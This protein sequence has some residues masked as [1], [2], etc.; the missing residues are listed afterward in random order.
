MKKK[1]KREPEG[2]VGKMKKKPESRRE[3]RRGRGKEE[4]SYGNEIH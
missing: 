2:N 4:N 1:P 3:M